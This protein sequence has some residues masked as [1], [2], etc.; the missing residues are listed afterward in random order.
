[1]AAN[2]SYKLTYLDVIGLAEGVRYLFHFN[3]CSFEDHRLEFDAID[4]EK[5][6]VFKRFVYGKE[7]IKM[8]PSTY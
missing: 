7:W 5:N 3:K 8:K 1:M 2:K 4:G 6:P